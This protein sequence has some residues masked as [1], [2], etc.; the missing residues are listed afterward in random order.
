VTLVAAAYPTDSLNP[1]RPNCISSFIAD[2]ELWSY[3]KMDIPL[4]ISR[5]TQ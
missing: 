5:W 4:H 3:Q 2:I 1:G